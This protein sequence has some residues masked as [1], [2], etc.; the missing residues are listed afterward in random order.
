MTKLKSYVK[1]TTDFVQ[2]IENANNIT[3]DSH[4]V[5]LVSLDVWFLYTNIPRREA[6]EAV[7]KS[8]KF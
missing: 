4:L 3:D 5:S 1:D 6:I 7:R 2:E 8:S